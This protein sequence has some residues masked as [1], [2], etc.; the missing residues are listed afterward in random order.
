M[1]T[2][3]AIFKGASAPVD[4]VRGHLDRTA[5][6]IKL[7]NADEVAQ[8]V[9]MVRET[10]ERDGVIFVAGNG[11]SATV[12]GAWVN[13]LSANSVVPG[14]RGFRVMSL[15]DSGP[16]VTALGNDVKFEEVFAE[17]LRAWMRPGDLLIVMSCSGN[18]P[19]VVRAVE[20]AKESGGKTAG[21]VGFTGGKLK[22]LVELPIYIETSC[23]EYGPVEDAFSVVMHAVCG[24]IIMSRG[25]MMRH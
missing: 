11:G 12:A 15:A 9:E 23:D 19:N 10:W 21:V 25:R 3:E 17:Q 7:I 1:D 16:T 14:Q 2:M 22:D 8:L 24:Y 5:E 4:Y 20:Q 13:D 18:S 6:V